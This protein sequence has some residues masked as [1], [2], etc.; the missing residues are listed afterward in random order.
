MLSNDVEAHNQKSLNKLLR[1]VSL[2]K[3]TFSLI[4]V[5]CNYVDLSVQVRTWLQDHCP[6]ELQE[7]TLKPHTPSLYDAIERSL[8]HTSLLGLVV[9]GFETASALEDLLTATNRVRDKFREQFSFPLVLW[10]NDEIL[11]KFA[12]LAPD[13][14]SWMGVPIQ[15]TLPTDTLIQRLNREANGLFAKAME[16]GA[17]RFPRSSAFYQELNTQPQADLKVAY[18][19]LQQREQVLSPL[20]VASLQFFWGLDAYVNNQMSEAQ[21]YYQQSLTFWE[22]ALEQQGVNIREQPV[23]DSTLTPLHKLSSHCSILPQQPSYLTLCIERWGCVLFYMGLGWSRYAVL[24]QADYQR[25]KQQARDCYQTCI[26][27]LQQYNRLDLAA[28]FINAWGEALHRLEEWDPL[29]QVAKTSIK[30]HLVYFDPI[31]LAYSYGLLAEVALARSQGKEAEQYAQQALE[32]NQQGPIANQDAQFQYVELKWAQRHYSSLYHLLLAQAQQHL[33]L[34]QSATKNLETAKQACNPAYDPLL[35]TRILE[36]LRSHYYDQKCYLE[37]FETKQE[38]RSIEQQYGLRAFTGASRLQPE[39]EVISP[40]LIPVEHIH[41]ARLDTP[42]DKASQACPVTVTAIAASGRQQDVQRLIKRL[43]EARRQ[44]TVIHGP[45]GVGKS[46]LVNAGLVPALKQHPIGDRNAL[47]VVVSVYTDWVREFAQS[48]SAA[49]E[50]R[51]IDVALPVFSAEQMQNTTTLTPTLIQELRENAEHRSLL[52]VLIFDQLEEFFFV[53]PNP[54]TRWA[55][56]DFLGSCLNLPYIKVVFSL[57]E[58][59]LHYLLEGDRLHLDDITADI[60]GR[61]KRYPL[62]NFS[63]NE[64][65]ETIEKLTQRSQFYLKPNLINQ[66]VTDLAKSSGKVRPI[67]LQVVGTQLQDD[68]IVTLEQYKALGDDPKLVLVERFLEQV[69]RDCGPENE[70]IANLILFLLTDEKGTRPLKTKSELATEVTVLQTDVTIDVKRLTFILKILVESGLVMLLPAISAERYQLVHDYLVSFIQRKQK[71]GLLEKIS[72]LQKRDEESQAKIEQLRQEKELSEALAREERLK[73][74][75]DRVQKQRRHVVGFA[76]IVTVLGALATGLAALT[77]SQAHQLERA[78]TQAITAEIQA[79]TTLSSSLLTSGQHLD[80]LVAAIKGGNQ[81]QDSAVP[82]DIQFATVSQLLNTLHTVQEYNRLDGHSDWVNHVSFSPDGQL[83]ASASADR[84]V[85]LWENNGRLRRSLPH[86][87]R[88]NSVVFSP[89]GQLIVSGS[90]DK[91]VRL[92]SR[93]GDEITVIREQ[94]GGHQRSITSLSFSPD[95]QMFASASDDRTVKLWQRDGT[96]IT[97]LEGHADRVKA[98]SFSPDGKVI[99]SASWDKTVKLWDQQGDLLDTLEHDDRVTTVSFSPKGD[100]ATGSWDG[101]VRIWDRAGK[102][103]NPLTGH[104]DRITSLDFS[105]DGKTLVVVSADN[106][107]KFWTLDRENGTFEES[108][109]HSN[110]AIPVINNA[111]FA[112]SSSGN[113]LAFAGGGDNAIRLWRLDGLKPTTLTGHDG[114]IVSVRF[115]P[116]GAQIATA[117][118]YT[119]TSEDE[120]KNGDVIIWTTAEQREKVLPV[121]GS[122]AGIEFS[123]DGEQLAIAEN[124]V[125]DNPSSAEERPGQI[126]LWQINGEASKTITVQG[127]ISSISFSPDGKLMASAYM[128]Q[129]TAEGSKVTVWDLNTGNELITFHAHDD[130]ITTIHF[131]PDSQII[132][133]ASWDNTV[134]LWNLQGEELAVLGGDNGYTDPVTDVSF[135][136]NTEML[137]SSSYDNTIKLWTFD[138]ELLHTLKGHTSTVTDIDFNAA[139][140]QLIAASADQT[141]TVWS[142]NP[143]V[144]TDSHLLTSL[145]SD[146]AI[147]SIS[148]SPDSSLVASATADNAVLLNFNLENLLTLGCDWLNAYLTTNQRIQS[149]NNQ[150]VCEG[151]QH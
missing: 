7:I 147:Q 18:Q 141:L 47:P 117:G 67:E 100:L 64:A 57:R 148:W 4:V 108:E 13:F 39:K 89:D 36:A 54:V 59:Y 84:T 138:G 66:L 6:F 17:G 76:G 43:G 144:P 44:L 129:E 42:Q 120:I 137:V 23:D 5:R 86:D 48:L 118:D 74:R 91:T 40:A 19:D 87:A 2:A 98:V 99:A 58:D 10:V 105:P 55:F 107:V 136:P 49:F 29:E 33:Q 142:V 46:S 61:D 31:R 145:E 25:G 22:Q 116:D 62:D 28:K 60:L 78:K 101:T 30:V 77:Y 12:A 113:K 71:P 90:D 115:S 83:I 24:N 125:P 150:K 11:Q 123:P 1:A 34:T 122:V 88:V 151:N 133:S 27:G 8:D 51:G 92:W 41:D 134:K 103:L 95:A 37:A 20:L 63:P 72:E 32:V 114:P 35:Y 119:I 56:W 69:I 38:Q 85:K 121:N 14:N 53:Y 128:L 70:E 131:S 127:S 81:L 135:A 9:S 3:G 109:E 130:R 15:F 65:K 139:G 96:L 50:E 132:A 52:T 112:P 97:T 110:I 102:I 104:D 73:R 93:A 45:S 68:D 80:A 126:R 146:G 21:A 16:V 143:T 124:P 140:D 111:N 106:V 26:Q 94:Q 82:A 79:N 149:S 75:F